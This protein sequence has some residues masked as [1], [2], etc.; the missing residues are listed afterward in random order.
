LRAIVYIGITVLI[1]F[2]FKLGGEAYVVHSV[3][4]IPGIR[5]D[6]LKEYLRIAKYAESRG[7]STAVGRGYYRGWYSIGRTAAIDARVP[8]D[9]LFITRWSD[10]A[11]VR[12]MRIN[13]RYLGVCRYFNAQGDTLYTPDYHRFVGD[14]INGLVVS[15]ATLLW[16]AHTVGHMGVKMYLINRGKVNPTDANGKSVNDC[17]REMQGVNL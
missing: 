9:S 14:T 17:I 2:P 16:G 6:G 10:T 7:D 15:K 12:L 1:C 8:Y 13:W 3:W 4:S 5:Y 11:M